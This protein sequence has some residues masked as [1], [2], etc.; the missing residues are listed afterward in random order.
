MVR[1]SDFENIKKGDLLVVEFGKEIYPLKGC[2]HSFKVLEN[3]SDD[4]EII[5]QNKGNIYFNYSM[6]LNGNS[7][8]KSVIKHW[9]S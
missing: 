2:L 9:L 4:R 8:V 6:F 7:I 3:K 1:I 5:L